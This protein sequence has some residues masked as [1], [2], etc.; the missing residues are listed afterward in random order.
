MVRRGGVRLA[1]ME[2]LAA[3]DQGVLSLMSG[4][5]PEVEGG[6][7]VTFLARAGGVTVE[8][9]DGHE[10]AVRSNGDARGLRSD[11]RVHCAAAREDGAVAVGTSEAHLFLAR[12][13]GLEPVKDFDRAEGRERW[14]TP[15]GGP[16]DVRSLSASPDGAL[17][18]NVHV[19]GILRSDDGGETWA[20]TAIPIEEDVHQVLAHPDRP[21]VVLA[22]TAY[23]L[24][25][26]EDRGAN[27]ETL[28]QGLEPHYARA[29]AAAGD[30]VLLS[31]SAGP[32]G[33]QA[34]LYRLSG[35]RFERC[36][37]P[38]PFGGN[39]D[40]HRLV[41]DGEVVAAA[42]PSGDVYLSEDAGES[43]E[44]IAEVPTGVHSLT[45]KAP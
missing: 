15:W 32:G 45:L 3:T 33:G 1:A 26:S 38:D 2:L 24:A 27:W 20:P 21:G 11:L 4:A 6:G 28:D 37:L 7:P 19:G 14:H 23:G 22:A 10:V 29:V 12:D 8:V 42:L 40:T 41:A 13:K 16:P 44:R 30:T 17:Y 43:W 25:S 5:T 31:A 39:L 34:A 9:R 36:D 18:A 35:E